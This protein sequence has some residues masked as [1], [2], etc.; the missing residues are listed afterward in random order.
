MPDANVLR[1][2]LHHRS[3]LLE[4]LLVSGGL[5]EDV[6]HLLLCKAYCQEIHCCFPKFYYCSYFLIDCLRSSVSSTSTLLSE[7]FMLRTPILIT[8]CQSLPIP[9]SISLNIGPHEILPDLSVF[10]THRI[11]LCNP[12]A[13]IPAHLFA[14]LP[15]LWFYSP[16]PANSFLQQQNLSLCEERTSSSSSLIHCRAVQ[17]VCH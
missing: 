14:V 1:W 6:V 4:D 5:Q 3:L 13:H 7:F 9:N 11:M 15:L 10:Q 2:C 16:A 8:H 12:L 17:E